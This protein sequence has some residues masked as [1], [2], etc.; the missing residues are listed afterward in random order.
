M[1]EIM[2]EYG[3]T[4]LAVTGMLLFLGNVSGL[5]LSQSGVLM[6]MIQLWLYGG[7]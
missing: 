5:L 1:K 4:F 6:K 7:V 3:G 2:E